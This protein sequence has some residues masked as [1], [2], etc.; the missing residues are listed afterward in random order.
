MMQNCHVEPVYTWGLEPCE[1]LESSTNSYVTARGADTRRTRPGLGAASSRSNVAEPL[2]LSNGR[3]SWR[4]KGTYNDRKKASSATA[5]SSKVLLEMV[6]QNHRLFGTT[7]GFLLSYLLRSRM[8]AT[9]KI[10]FRI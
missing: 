4:E 8:S 6:F 7:D 3:Q 2:P 5:P 1:G 10:A 9:S